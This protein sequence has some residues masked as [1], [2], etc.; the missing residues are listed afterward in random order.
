L[1]QA[2]A[3]NVVVALPEPDDRILARRL[4]A[5]HGWCIAQYAASLQKLRP[6]V[7]AGVLNVA[8]GHAIYT[9]PS[10][11]SFT[12]GLGMKG[13]VSADELDRIEEYF[14]SRGHATRVDVTPYSDP[15]LRELIWGRGYRVSEVTAVLVRNLE[16]ELPAV[17]W[18]EGVHVRWAEP[19]ECDLWID[20]VARCFFAHDPGRE[21]R[22]NMSALF[23]VPDSLNVLAM[24]NRALVGVAGGMI[25]ADR[26]IAPLFASATLPPFRRRG[27]H[28][29]MLQ[30]RL[31]QAKLEGCKLAMITATPGS[32]SERNLHRHGFVPCDEKGTYVKV[33][34]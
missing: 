29:A 15:S 8:G 19:H 31:E 4:E 6:Q 11:F 12:V 16:T 27:V 32:E 14:T 34:D 9:G 23:H 21:R 26:E 5:L 2:A 33:I 25:P 10:P 22:A 1:I 18:P 13:P 3:Q 17:S 7:G 20:V 24:C 30:M 28:R